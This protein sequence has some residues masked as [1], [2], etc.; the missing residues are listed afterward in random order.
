[1]SENKMI[2][3][4][5]LILY[6]RLFLT[7]IIG[8]IS[9]RYILLALGAS[10]YGL[11]SVVGGIVFMMAFLNN[12]MIS[13]TYRFIAFELGK[14]DTGEVNKVFNISLIIHLSL[15]VLTILLAETMG[16]FYIKNYLNIAEGKIGDA[17]FVFR[18]SIL[19]AVF[20]IFSVPYQGLITAKEKFIVTA[21]VE[22]IRSILA[23]CVVFLVLIYSG[24]RL[25]L[26]A[27]MI[28]LISVIPP[29]IYFLYTKFKYARFIKWNFQY[30]KG[31]YKEMIDFSI[32][33]LFGALAAAAE[34]QVS[35]IIINLFFGTVINAAFAIATQ[36][37]NIVKLFAQSLNKA[38]IPQ[39]TKNY[40]RGNTQRYMQLVIYSSKYSF[41]LIMILSVPILLETK[42]LLNLFLKE[43]PNYTITF[44]QIMVINAMIHVMNAGIP[45]AI[46]ATGKIKYFQIIISTLKLLAL[47][48]GYFLFKS[49][50]EPYFMPLAFTMVSIISLIIE[51]ILLKLLF[52][53]N[54]KEFFLKAYWKMILVTLP[55]LPMFLIIPFFDEG[56]YRFIAFSTFSVICLLIL[57]YMVGME[58]MEKTIIRTQIK[59]IIFKK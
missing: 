42:Y 31:K 53:F 33:I 46:Q 15:V 30:G 28:A 52:Q 17:L 20:S 5:S 1:M 45:A 3:K 4:N 57:I 38:V 36:V 32:W 2:V 25:R 24:N 7:S 13:A 18:F 58:T 49:G 14:G 8:L 55:V 6:I 21:S 59:Q 41:F 16:V 29:I 19:S 39:I 47:P 48:I 11:Y 12:V 54:V 50:H 27:L 34:I 9:V 37:N 26:Y 10:D 40:S 22:V 44:V 35:V 51:Q 23:L 43:V 56:F